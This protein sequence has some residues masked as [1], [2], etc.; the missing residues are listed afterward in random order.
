V[1]YD[2]PTPS[3]TGTFLNPNTGVMCTVSIQAAVPS[4][5]TLNN[6]YLGDEVVLTVRGQVMSGA[7]N[8]AG[9]TNGIMQFVHDFVISQSGI[10]SVV[11]S[12]PRASYMV[13]RPSLIQPVGPDQ[14]SGLH[15]IHGYTRDSSAGIGSATELYE[16][17]LRAIGL[18]AANVSVIPSREPKFAASTPRGLKVGH[19]QQ[20]G[21][22]AAANYPSPLA[23]AVTTVPEIPGDCDADRRITL[24]D[25]G[26]FYDCFVGLEPGGTAACEPFDFHGDENIDL[27]DFAGFQNVFSDE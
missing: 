18:G 20:N 2:S 9:Q 24:A 19:T 6:L 8:N 13:T 3:T 5:R 10:F 21:N 27:R 1:R 23:L 7:N 17:R 15:R 12:G 4:G 26:C 14:S 22:P 16:V 11:G 25:Y